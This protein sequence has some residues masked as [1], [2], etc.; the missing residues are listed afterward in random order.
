[1]RYYV[2]GLLL[3][4]RAVERCEAR[5]CARDLREQVGSY[6]SML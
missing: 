2:E 3:E 1:M 6:M 5:L 4:P